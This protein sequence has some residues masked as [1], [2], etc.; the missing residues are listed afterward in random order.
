MMGFRKNFKKTL[1]FHFLND[2]SDYP[3]LIFGE[4]TKR[5]T[6]KRTREP[7]VSGKLLTYPS[8]TPTST[9]TFHLGQ[10]VG[11][12]E[13]WVDSFPEIYNDPI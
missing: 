9:L 8:P 11:L 13:G 3:V 10:N 7:Y 4:G 6:L 2:W 5:L 1:I 12:G